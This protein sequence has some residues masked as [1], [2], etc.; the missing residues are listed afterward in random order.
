MLFVQ[1][2]IRGYNNNNVNSKWNSEVCRLRFAFSPAYYIKSERLFF[3][4]QN[5][6]FFVCRKE[7]QHKILIDSFIQK[8]VTCDLFR[9]L[10]YEL[11]LS[12]F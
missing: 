12:L 2:I 9:P 3:L 11:S 5:E 8:C 6:K 4:S 7:I 10:F 1:Y